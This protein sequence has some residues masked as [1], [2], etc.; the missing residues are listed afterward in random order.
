LQDRLRR[1]LM[2]PVCLYIYILSREVFLV[3]S[4]YY[5]AA[6]LE[7]AYRQWWLEA[8]RRKPDLVFDFAELRDA[9]IVMYIKNIGN[10]PAYSIEAVT[11]TV[12]R[13]MLEKYRLLISSKELLIEQVPQRWCIG[14]GREVRV[15]PGGREYIEIDLEELKRCMQEEDD[16]ALFRICYEDPHLNPKA[17]TEIIEIES[18]GDFYIH[19]S[20][21]LKEDL[22]GLLTK[23]PDVF[24]DAYKYYKAY[25][26]SVKYLTKRRSSAS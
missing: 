12:R 2:P 6:S 14:F 19:R 8:N 24:K 7:L 22:P 13:S 15:P 10:A 16:L 23:L 1:Y 21:R 4:S 9:K 5:Y 17:C 26:I 18:F 11:I 25:K 3:F 20:Y